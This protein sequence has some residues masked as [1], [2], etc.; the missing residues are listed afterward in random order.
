MDTAKK[1]RE[2][3]QLKKMSQEELAYK[4][5]VSQVTVG[6]WEQGTSIKHE[7]LKK[8]SEI[9]EVPVEFLLEDKQINISPKIKN[10][11]NNYVG[12][13]FNVEN[14]NNYPHIEELLSSIN[15]LLIKISNKL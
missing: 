10:S 15:N 2:L 4:I 12:Y 8:L 1:L 13:E 3:R 6:K 7:N 5:G 14:N 9:F 11:T